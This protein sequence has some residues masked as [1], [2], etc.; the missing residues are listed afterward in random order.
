MSDG[1]GDVFFF[2]MVR[3]WMFLRTKMER[4]CVGVFLT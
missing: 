1:Q 3:S 2:E 4:R